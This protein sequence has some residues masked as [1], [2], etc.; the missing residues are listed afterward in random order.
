VYIGLSTLC[1]CSHVGVVVV[2]SR[3]LVFLVAPD[4]VALKGLLS[5]LFDIKQQEYLKLLLSV[6]L[7]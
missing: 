4:S 6:R 1:T 5:R 3:A 2:N 7:I